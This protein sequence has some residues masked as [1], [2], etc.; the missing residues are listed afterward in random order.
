MILIV[1][2]Y[3]TFFTNP[4]FFFVI[5]ASK[6]GCF[7]NNIYFCKR[8]VVESTTKLIRNTYL[9]WQQQY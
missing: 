8:Y 3:S 6:F 2:F 7:G 4:L 9:L 1:F 5:T